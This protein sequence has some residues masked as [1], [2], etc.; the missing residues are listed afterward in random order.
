MV[1]YDGSHGWAPNK[2]WLF[3]ACEAGIQSK[4]YLTDPTSFYRE[5]ISEKADRSD[6]QDLICERV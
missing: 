2:R 6:M 3:S 4:A 1:P 5:D